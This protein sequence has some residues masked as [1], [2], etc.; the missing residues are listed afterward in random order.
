MHNCDSE[1][2]RLNCYRKVK[3]RSFA[4]CVIKKS[5]IYLKICKKWN[6]LAYTGQKWKGVGFRDEKDF[7]YADR[8]N[9]EC[10]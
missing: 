9:A 5:T 3:S 8:G 2:V 4:Y 10:V 6:I 1:A 7:G